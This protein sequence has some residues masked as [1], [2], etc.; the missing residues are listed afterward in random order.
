MFYHNDAFDSVDAVSDSSG[1][2]VVRYH[3]SPFGQSKVLMSN[4]AKHVSDLLNLGYAGHTSVEDTRLV[5][6][7]GRILDTVFARFLSP[8]PFIQ[9]VYNIQ[10]LNRYSY[11]LNNP[12]KFNDPSGKLFNFLKKL[13]KVFAKAVFAIAVTVLV[14]YVMPSQVILQAAGLYQGFLGQMV[15]GAFLQG[16]VNF[17]GTLLLTG[18]LD[19]AL[20]SGR[21]AM[22]KSARNFIFKNIF[23]NGIPGITLPT[24]QM[25]FEVSAISMVASQYYKS[26]IGFESQLETS[27]APLNRD[28]NNKKSDLNYVSG[29][30][31]SWRIPFKDTGHEKLN[32]PFTPA[33]GVIT[34]L[35]FQNNIKC[36]AC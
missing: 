17:A 21:D 12:F 19:D 10:N 28:A 34:Y 31:E 13:A 36:A 11:A 8:D 24:E 27:D 9:D 32:D 25:S 4:L 20:K 7:K 3:H 26:P 30:H 18:D 33:T 29:M 35:A 2:I 22:I 1:S 15:A 5:Y 14:M 16:S 6:M 23:M